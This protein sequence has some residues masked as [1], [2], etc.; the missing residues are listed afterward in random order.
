MPYVDP[1]FI[2]AQ[3]L[4]QA[5]ADYRARTGRDWP[6]AILMANHGLIVAGDDP[7]TI[8]A[9]TD[10]DPAEDRRA[11]WGTTGRRS[12]L[13]ESTRIGD[14]NGVRA[15]GS[16]PRLRALLGRRSAPGR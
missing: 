12:R 4:K 1:G 2:L 10:G 3:T 13:A 6:K 8:R 9:N 7:E 14:A 16:V 15:P 5:L 11:D